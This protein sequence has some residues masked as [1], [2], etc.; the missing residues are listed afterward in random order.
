MSEIVKSL[1]KIRLSY[2]KKI[3]RPVIAAKF[4]FRQVQAFLGQ[5]CLKGRLYENKRSKISCV[6]SQRPTARIHDRASL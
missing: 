6:G 1:Q 5:K 4:S 2:R 3:I